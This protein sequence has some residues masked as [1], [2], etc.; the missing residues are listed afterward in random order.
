[1]A[2][3]TKLMRLTNTG[4]SFITDEFLKNPDADPIT[5]PEAIDQL[6]QD[7]SLS[8]FSRA[9]DEVMQ[10]FPDDPPAGDAS[11]SEQIHLALRLPRSVAMDIRIWQFLT[12]IAHPEYVRYRWGGTGKVSKERFLGGIKRNAFARLWW[13]AE[14]M[15][16]G[17]DYSGI[18]PCFESQDLYEAVFGRSFSKFP[19]AAKAFVEVVKNQER[20]IIREVAK[21]FNFMLSTF[22]LEDLPEEQVKSLV[23]ERIAVRATP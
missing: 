6:T 16:N 11:L 22:V 21:D 8:G 15:K 1:M 17:E 5:L 12:C 2:G 23:G 4:S 9:V 14:I 7:I 3:Y 10:R 20:Q 19:S 18:A 13:A